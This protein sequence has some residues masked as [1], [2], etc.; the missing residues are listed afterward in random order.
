[1]T[2]SVHEMNA[3][4]LEAAEFRIE[5]HNPGQ[6]PTIDFRQLEH[7]QDGMKRM[8]YE[9]MLKV[10]GSIMTFGFFGAF[11]V[12]TLKSQPGRRFLA[13][14]HGRLKVFKQFQ[15]LDSDGNPIHEF[16]YLPIE[17]QDEADA[18][19]RLAVITSQYNLMEQKGLETFL[20]N[21]GARF[22]AVSRYANF[23]SPGI[24]L[25]RF[26]GVAIK[27]DGDE[28]FDPEFEDEAERLAENPE[29]PIVPQ[30]SEKHN[31]VIIVVDNEV[32]MTR[33]KEILGLDHKFQCYKGKEVGSTLV[34]SFD[35]FIEKYN[36]KDL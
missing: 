8:P 36:A 34:I 18:A 2:E 1:M 15:P 12:F 31:A 13:D 22:E 20:K 30:F 21:K 35:H 23:E 29:F 7:F 16:P 33:L 11:F 27:K 19:E 28:S 32:N 9:N 5:V 3:Q 14:G 17:A 25:T 10:K 6:L 26:G 4:E 24:D